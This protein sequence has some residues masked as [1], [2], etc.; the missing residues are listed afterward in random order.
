MRDDVI[1]ETQIEPHLAWW[2]ERFPVHEQ[3]TANEL[4]SAVIK[5]VEPSKARFW[6]RGRGTKATV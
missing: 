6:L 1:D 5:V 4:E 2:T 3:R